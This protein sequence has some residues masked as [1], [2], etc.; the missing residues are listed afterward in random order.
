MI[1]DLSPV[2]TDNMRKKREFYEE[3]D[4]KLEAFYSVNENV[5]MREHTLRHNFVRSGF[6]PIPNRERPFL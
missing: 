1:K 3:P 6:L 2:L 5:V 4:K